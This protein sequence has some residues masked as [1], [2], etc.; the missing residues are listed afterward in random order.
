[1]SSTP[2]QP[3]KSQRG[4]TRSPAQASKEGIQHRALGFKGL[5]F[6]FK[7]VL[8]RA[9]TN[10]YMYVYIWGFKRFLFFVVGLAIGLGG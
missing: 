6:S 10:K 4:T 9:K 2:T 1:M 7:G 5:G 8:M 3:Q